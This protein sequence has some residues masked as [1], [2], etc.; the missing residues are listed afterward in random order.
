M[1]KR[2]DAIACEKLAL[3]FER[4]NFLVERIGLQF[5]HSWIH[6]LYFALVGRNDV[7]A[8][9]NGRVE[10]RLW[11]CLLMALLMHCI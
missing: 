2:F 11:F 4:C 5:V 1:R 8:K 10:L 3:F 6:H 9:E 7:A